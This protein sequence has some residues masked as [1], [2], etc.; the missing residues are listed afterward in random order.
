M[1]VK[2]SNLPS[3]QNVSIEYMQRRIGAISNG[4]AGINSKQEVIA[5]VEQMMADGWTLFETHYNPNGS[6]SGAVAILH[7]FVKYAA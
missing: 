1:P 4:A 6:D 2:V 5:E 7:I 3:G